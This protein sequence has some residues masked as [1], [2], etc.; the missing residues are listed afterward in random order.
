MRP[1]SIPV[2]SHFV[3]RH[4]LLSHILLPG[5][6]GCHRPT[7]AVRAPGP[8]TS[9]TELEQFLPSCPAF[10]ANV[11]GTLSQ[12]QEANTGGQGQPAGG[13]QLLFWV[14]FFPKDQTKAHKRG[15][16]DD[17]VVLAENTGLA[18]SI[19]RDQA[20]LLVLRHLAPSSGLHRDCPY[21]V[22]RC[23]FKHSVHTRH[24]IKINHSLENNM[25][26]GSFQFIW[27]EF[28]S[29]KQKQLRPCFTQK[30]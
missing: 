10:E 9:Q 27:K 29:E 17:S 28:Q 14:Y 16:R 26:S 11:L 2:T 15:W 22:Y 7:T 3:P 18:P 25:T 13:K 24:K 12:R 8:E 23:I 6:L 19:D 4:S 5:N 30:Y 21:V 20:V 1:W